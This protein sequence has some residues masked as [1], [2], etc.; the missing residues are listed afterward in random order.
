MTF[1]AGGWGGGTT[2]LSNI[3]ALDASQ[4]ETSIERSY[5]NGRWYR[6]KL[7][8][9]NEQI[10]VSLDERP[11]IRIDISKRIVGMRHGEIDHCQPLG[12]MTWRT[13]AAIRNIKLNRRPVSG[14]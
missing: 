6:F 10:V 3:G 14:R 13:K 11:I 12:L 8:V 7:A 9:S 5:E 4:N 1:V 2:G